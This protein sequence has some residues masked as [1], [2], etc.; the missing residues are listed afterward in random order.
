M[1]EP[2]LE[3]GC[4]PEPPLLL[5][6]NPRQF[7]KPDSLFRFLVICRMVSSSAMETWE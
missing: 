1:G 2:D 3:E 6:L 5:Q 4:S 7:H